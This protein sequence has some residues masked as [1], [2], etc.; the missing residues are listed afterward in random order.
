MTFHTIRQCTWQKKKNAGKR[1]VRGDADGL[2]PMSF[3]GSYACRGPA[4]QEV[5]QYLPVNG[6]QYSFAS[7]SKVSLY[8]SK[9]SLTFASPIFF[10]S[11]FSRSK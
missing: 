1:R 4:Y 8:Q 3:Q 2:W 9:S 5:T 7:L 6:K 10:A 11:L